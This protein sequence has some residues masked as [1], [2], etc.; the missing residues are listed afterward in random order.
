MD[1]VILQK[2]IDSVTDST[3]RKSFGVKDDEINSLQCEPL[4]EREKIKQ[5][6]ADN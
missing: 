3:I 2:S 5:L 6:E 4:S 1:L